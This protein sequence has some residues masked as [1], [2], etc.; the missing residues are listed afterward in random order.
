M[1]GR[2]VPGPE[3]VLFAEIARHT[4]EIINECGFDGIYFDAI[5]GSDILAGE[6]YFWYYGTKFIF[7]VARHLRTSGWNGDELNVAS[8]VALPFQVAGMGQAGERI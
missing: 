4:A 3:T 1:F 6:E 7:E 2:F 5:D 8:L